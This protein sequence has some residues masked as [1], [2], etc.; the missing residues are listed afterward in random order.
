MERSSD[1]ALDTSS[2]AAD[3]IVYAAT[4]AAGNTAPHPARN[5]DLICGDAIAAPLASFFRIDLGAFFEL[6]SRPS[7]MDHGMLPPCAGIENGAAPPV[8]P[9]RTLRGH[10]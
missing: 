1:I 9:A 3:T 2:E 4:P 7:E 10:G 6:L 8:P 5:I